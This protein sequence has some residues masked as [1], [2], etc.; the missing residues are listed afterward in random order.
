[1]GLNETPGAERIQ[2]G[3]F[4]L[5]NAGKSSL[6]N[7]ITNQEVSLVSE[8]KGT[9]TDPVKKSMELLPLGPVTLIDTPGFDDEGVLG[10]QRVRRTREALAVCDLALLVTDH[11]RLSPEEQEL[12]VLMERRDLPHLIVRNKTDCFPPNAVCGETMLTVSARDGSGVEELKNAMARA[13]QGREKRQRLVA[14]LL[15]PGDTVVLVIPIDKA[16]PKGRLI[17]PQQQVL[18]D[19]LDAGALSLVTGVERLEAALGG[20]RRDPALV[21]TDSQVFAS[22]IKRVPERLP[23]TSFSILMAR[24]KGFLDEAVRGAAAINY[25]PD[26]ARVLIGEGCT[27]HRQCDDIGT[28]K[29]PDWLQK[30]SGRRLEFSFTSGHGFS[31]NPAEYDLI[32]HCGGCMLN[33]REM[34]NRMNAARAAGV[35]ITNYGIA[36]AHMNGIL[37][38][39]IAPLYNEL[40]I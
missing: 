18:R 21:I 35:P 16:A 25:L 32:V 26:G 38:R 23:L 31:E 12:L 33:D 19:V 39:S 17:L 36:I 29:L 20:L 3:F 14:D 22:V 2:I 5:R 10:E 9:T 13:M 4:G 30:H 28:V 8:V 11:D 7:R 34:Q 37:R 40:P 15:A 24:Y 6:I 27:H 1:M